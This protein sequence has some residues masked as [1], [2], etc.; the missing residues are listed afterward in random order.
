MSNFANSPLTS[1]SLLVVGDPDSFLAN[2]DLL[3]IFSSITS[4]SSVLFLS[5]ISFFLNFLESIC[6]SIFVFYSDNYLIQFFFDLLKVCKF[7]LFFASPC[8]HLLL[9]MIPRSPTSALEYFAFIIKVLP[10]CFELVWL[11]FPVLSFCFSWR[12][13]SFQEKNPF[14]QNEL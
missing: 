11:S 3:F 14:R 13:T 10:I 9:L 12:Y 1:L 6:L 4:S 8:F 5:L 7:A 2:S